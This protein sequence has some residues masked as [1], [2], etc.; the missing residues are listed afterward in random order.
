MKD[1]ADEIGTATYVSLATFRKSGEAVRTPVWIAPDVS[2]ARQGPLYVFSAGNAGKV[3]RL[4]L[5]SRAELAVCD[6]RGRVLGSW[7]GARAMLVDDAAE[8][9]RALAAL[10]RKYGWQMWLADVGAKLTGKF[11]RRA[12]IRVELTGE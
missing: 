5:S 12:Y 3:K 7:R 9:D 4:R 11:H 2:A 10:R 8:T 6:V 1:T